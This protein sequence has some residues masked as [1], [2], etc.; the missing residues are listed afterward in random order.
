[1]TAAWEYRRATWAEVCDLGPLG[2][3]LVP[4]PPIQEMKNLLGQMQAGEPMY[5]MEREA[6][7][8]KWNQEEAAERMRGLFPIAGTLPP[9]SR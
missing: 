7:A 9:E 5:A 6:L 8:A 1:V 2:W 3:R 4:I